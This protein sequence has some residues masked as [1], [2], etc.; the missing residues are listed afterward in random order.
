MTTEATATAVIRLSGVSVRRGGRTILG[1]LDWIVGA[2]EHWV[3]IGPNGSGKTT[4]VQVASTNLWPTT[5][6]VE[7]LGET[8]GR[9]DARELRRRVGYASAIQEP[10][11]DPELTAR[12]V[13]MTARHGALAPWWHVF[14]DA[15]RTRADGLLD[16]LGV[17]AL[18][19]R[20][21]GSLSTGERRR[22]QIA[23]ALMPDPELLILDEPAAGLD[24]GARE[25]LVRDL[26]RLAATDRPLAIVLVTHHVEEIPAGFEHA[27][28][29]AAGRI[30]AAGPIEPVL[31]GP[32]P[33]AAFGVAL[34]FDREAGRY[35]ASLDGADGDDDAPERVLDTPTSDRH[36]GDEQ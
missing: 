20:D 7:I 21:V 17:G 6:S 19:G 34:R 22:V 27:L 26:G 25:T 32:A 16:R 30:A 12:D 11:F 14:D 1:P 24:V 9:V 8:I 31:G 18:A 4:L 29:L 15:D 3:V 35:R 2:G 23:R 5:G 10:A 33:A 13:V 28:V 36:A